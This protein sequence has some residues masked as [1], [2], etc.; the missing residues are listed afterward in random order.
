MLTGDDEGLVLLWD[1]A[2]P[3]THP[4]ELGYHQGAVLAAAALPDG[5]I[6]TGDSAGRLVAWDPTRAGGEP[7]RLGHRDWSMPS[8]VAL[9]PDGRVVTGDT[10]GQVI[11]PE[12]SGQRICG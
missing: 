12:L 2:H 11:C 10:E 6:V 8:A 5:H 7:V 1:P 9:L 3:G 4:V